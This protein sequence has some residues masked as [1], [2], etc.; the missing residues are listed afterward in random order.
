LKISAVLYDN[1]NNLVSG[2]D[3]PIPKFTWYSS[4]GEIVFCDQM[5]TELQE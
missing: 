5:G 4:D 3:T 2:I 1:T